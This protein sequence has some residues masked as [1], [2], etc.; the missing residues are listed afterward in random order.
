MTI[1][2]CTSIWQ[3]GRL[4]P[5][6]DATVHVMSHA[7][8]YGSSVFEG[9]RAYDTP[10]GPALFRLSAHVRRLFDSARIYRIDIPYEP[11]AIAEACRAVVRANGLSS[12]YVRPIAFRGMGGLGIAAKTPIDVAIA[13]ITW[14]P[15]LGAGA[16]ERGIDAC[17][18]SWARPSGV[19]SLAKAGG[20]YL[21][22]QLVALEAR[23]NGYG[24]GIALDASGHLSEGSGE[25]LFLVRDGVLFTPT[26]AASLLPGITRDTITTLARAAGLE[27]REE[28]LPREALY[29]ADEAFFTGTAAEITPIRSVDGLVLGDGCRGPI[30]HA[31][32]RAFFGLFSGE[33]VD[34]WGW[35]DPVNGARHASETSAKHQELIEEVAS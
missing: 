25:N 29:V 20:H 18:S 10:D 33:T 28:P 31:M 11:H 15:Y 1:E 16:L 5:W 19:P 2:P 6:H 14:G 4:V 3:N 35:L 26:R 21:G 34:V 27:V 12:A 13:A 7:L 24:E 30:T 17:V 22:S 23:R 32:Q 9:I 8:H